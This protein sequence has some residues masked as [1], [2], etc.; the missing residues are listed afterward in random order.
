MVSSLPPPPPFF[1]FFFLL[2]SISGY[3]FPIWFGNFR[4]RQVAMMIAIWL[5][6]LIS[7]E[8]RVREKFE[9]F[10]FSSLIIM[11]ILFPVFISPPPLESFSIL[12]SFWISKY[13]FV[14]LFFFFKLILIF[15]II[16]S[17][18]KSLFLVIRMLLLP[19]ASGNVKTDAQ[20]RRALSLTCV[21]PGHSIKLDSGVEIRF[22]RNPRHFRLVTS[23]PPPEADTGNDR[24]STPKHLQ[25]LSTMEDGT[26]P[27]Y[28]RPTSG[29]LTGSDRNFNPKTFCKRCWWLTRVHFR[30]FMA[31]PD[32]EWPEVTGTRTPRRWWL[33]GVDKCPGG[34]NAGS[35]DRWLA[36]GLGGAAPVT[37]SIPVFP[38]M[39][40]FYFSI[41]NC[42]RA[43][44]IVDWQLIHDFR[45]P[46]S[47]PLLVIGSH[48]PPSSFISFR[49]IIDLI[50]F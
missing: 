24:N 41:E 48:A 38:L 1:F 6:L 26:L 46:R 13:Q 27:V 5:L 39:N 18:L 49:F 4:R 22:H 47:S 25:E 37:S 42:N 50:W 28:F 20:R 40:L 2:P 32:R 7:G 17:F 12:F 29:P 36:L 21:S 11:M 3:W 15:L 31:G 23:G 44:L 45:L 33:S 19:V 9:Q 16:C 35:A 8:R 10:N 34:E 14:L 43:A 30:L